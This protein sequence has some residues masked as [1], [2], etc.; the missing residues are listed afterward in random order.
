MRF[1]KYHGTGNDF[2]MVEDLEDRIHLPR[3]VIAVACDRHRGI[4]A[5][6]L[7]R[8]VRGTEPGVDFV[9]D[10][11]NANGEVAE[12][13]GNGIRC[14]A[15]LVYERGLTTSSVVE[16]Q[17]LAGRKRLVLETDDGVVR[18]VTVDMGTPSIRRGAIGLAGAPDGTL[19]GERLEALGRTYEATAV[20]MGNPH[21]VVFL[22]PSDDL[23]AFD[24]RGVG[25][26]I[27]HLPAF[28][29]GANVEFVLVE[30]GRIRLR[31]WERGSGETM[32]CGTGACAALVASSLT[33]RCGRGAE[34]E[35]PGGVLRVAWGQ[36]DHVFLTGP[37]VHVFDGELTEG[38]M[39]SV[40][41]GAAR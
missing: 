40:L 16:V 24:V 11:A 4:G 22:E 26:A 1:A 2:L 19:V 20:S 3:E 25:S 17:T 23:E 8:I 12:M 10:Y 39:R 18:S 14:L 31:V 9:M 7:I 35:F 13:C 21:C 34:V 6:G 15:K 38:W 5:D 30:D 37:A 29:N 27:E 28:A 32:A 41:A 36:D 33:G